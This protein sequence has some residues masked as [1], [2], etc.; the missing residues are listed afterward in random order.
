M[1]YAAPRRSGR[2]V[3][4]PRDDLYLYHDLV[5]TEAAPEDRASESRVRPILLRWRGM[6]LAQTPS[7]R[8]PDVTGTPHRTILHHPTT[9]VTMAMHLRKGSFWVVSVTTFFSDHVFAPFEPIS[10]SFSLDL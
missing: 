4:R 10:I 9:M 2:E 7:M 8:S 3:R 6:Q 5:A 1:P